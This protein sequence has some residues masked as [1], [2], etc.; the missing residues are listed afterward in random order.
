MHCHIQSTCQYVVLERGWD[1]FRAC[2][3]HQSASV[4]GGSNAFMIC[5]LFQ[6][7]GSKKYIQKK[8]QHIT[9]IQTVV[10]GG[11]KDNNIISALG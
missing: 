1:F 10:K 7:L 11:N 9:N 6:A 8:T 3:G 4:L 2:N 5:S